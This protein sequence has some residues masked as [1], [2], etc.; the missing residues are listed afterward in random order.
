M[1]IR[2]RYTFNRKSGGVAWNDFL[3][4]ETAGSETALQSFKRIG[5]PYML[6]NLVDLR[7]FQHIDT[8]LRPEEKLIDVKPEVIKAFIES[9]KGELTIKEEK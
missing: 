1:I 9:C 7:L 8:G 5:A 3:T 6:A 2:I 4:S